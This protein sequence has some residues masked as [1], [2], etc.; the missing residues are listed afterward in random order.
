MHE[1]IGGHRICDTVIGET[2]LLSRKQ[3]DEVVM[4]PNV[5]HS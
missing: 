3:L 2:G 1:R 4:A 5:S